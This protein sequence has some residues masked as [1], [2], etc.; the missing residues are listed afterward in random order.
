M[1][2]EVL[3]LFPAKR[4]TATTDLLVGLNGAG[5]GPVLAPAHA[6]RQRWEPQCGFAGKAKLSSTRTT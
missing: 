2:D 4:A 1:D 5:L 3:V 6:L